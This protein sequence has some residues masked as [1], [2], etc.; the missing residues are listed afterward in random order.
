MRERESKKETPNHQFNAQRSGM[1]GIPSVSLNTRSSLAE[2]NSV[3]DE[4]CCDWL[5]RNAGAV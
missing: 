3:G 4:E 5:E 2:R 1:N